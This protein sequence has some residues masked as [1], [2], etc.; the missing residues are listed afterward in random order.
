MPTPVLRAL[1]RL[2]RRVRLAAPA[3]LLLVFAPSLG[4]QGLLTPPTVTISPAQASVNSPGLDITVSFYD[5]DGLD[6]SS[7]RMYLNGVDVTAQFSWPGSGTSGQSSGRVQLVAGDN[8]FTAEIMDVTETYGTA[9]ASYT[10]TAAPPPGP[11]A[12]APLPARADDPAQTAAGMVHAG[13]S[14]RRDMCVTIAAGPGAAYEC[15]DLRLAHALAPIRVLNAARTPVL[16]YNSQHASP[17][18]VLQFNLPMTAGAAPSVVTA[19]LRVGAVGGTRVER[20]RRTWSDGAWGGGGL[21]RFAISYD[22]STDATSLYQYEIEVLGTF[23]GAQTRMAL[24]TGDL[25]VVNRS[26]HEFGAGWSLAG[27]ERLIFLPDGARSLLVSGDGS[28]RVYRWAYNSTSLAENVDRPDSLVGV[29]INGVAHYTRRLPNGSVVWFD[30]TGRHYKTVTR[31]GHTTWF[32]YDGQGRLATI[33]LPRPAASTVE[34]QYYFGYDDQNGGGRLLYACAVVTGYACRNT[35]FAFGWNDRRL[36][37][38]TDVDERVVQFGYE[39][40]SRQVRTRTDRRGNT[41]WFAYDAAGKLRESS[42]AV[43]EMS[44]TIVNTFSAS[45]SAGL[46]A[47]VPVWNAFTLYDGPR[48][49]VPDHTS[50]WVNRWGA[51]TRTRNALGQLTYLTRSDTRFPALVTRVDNPDSTVTSAGYDARGNV[52]VQTDWSTSRVLANG[53]TAFATQRYTR[54]NAAWPDFVTE[55]T[56]PEGQVV[57][58]DYD[59]AGN[60][61]WQQTGRGDSTRVHFTWTDGQLTAVQTEAARRRGEQPERYAYGTRGNLSRVTSPLG[62][63]SE[64]FQDELGRD[65]ATVAPVD[66]T[67]RLRTSVRYD[68][69]GGDTLTITDGDATEGDLYV[70]KVFDAEGNPTMVR[71]WSTYDPRQIGTVTRNYEYDAAGRRISESGERLTAVRTYYDPAGNV[72][73]VTDGN[74]WTETAYDTLSRPVRRVTPARE[75]A[76]EGRYIWAT[77]NGTVMGSDVYPAFPNTAAGSFLIPGDT[78]VFRYHPLSGALIAADNR[79]AQIRRTYYPNGALKTDTLRIRTW[80]EI[81]EGG[82]FNQ[83]VYA[84]EFGY[85]L[86]GRRTWMEHPDAIEPVNGNTGERYSRQTYGYDSETGALAVVRDVLGLEYTFHYNAE[87]ALVETRHP[88]GR[89]EKLTY[90]ADGRRT[91]RLLTS[92]NYN[93]VGA[94]LY[95][96][97]DVDYGFDQR[98]MPSR[99]LDRGQDPGA[100][101]DHYFTYTQLG[102]VY[103]VKGSGYGSG[104]ASGLPATGETYRWDALGNRLQHQQAEDAWATVSEYI[105]NTTRLSSSHPPDGVANSGQPYLFA[106]YD[107]AGN[108]VWFTADNYMTN[109][110]DASMTY[111]FRATRSYYG[112]DGKLRAS[113]GNHCY[114]QSAPGQVGSVCK[115]PAYLTNETSGGFE[116]YRYDALGRRVLAR[117]RRDHNCTNSSACSS[118]I[119]RFVWDGDQILYEIQAEGGNVSAV[120]LESDNTYGNQYGRVLYTHGPGIDAPLDIIRMDHTPPPGYGFDAWGG[121][122]PVLPFGNWRGTFVGG[123]TAQGVKLPCDATYCLVAWPG[124]RYRAFLERDRP[125]HQQNFFGSLTTGQENSN[126]LMYMRNRYY[127]PLTGAFTQTDPI[128]LAGGLNSY[129]YAE[130]NPVSYS[131]PYGLSAQSN[132]C[133]LNPKLCDLAA[134]AIGGAAI[135]AGIQM[136]S[137]YAEGRPLGE[138]VGRAALTGGAAGAAL[139]GVGLAVKGWRGTRGARAAAAAASGGDD[140]F[141]AGSIVTRAVNTP[142][143]IV[144]L[145]ATIGI[146]G[147]HL[148]LG[149]VGVFARFADEV[150]LGTREMLGIL[151]PILNEARDAGF[152]T[153]RITGVRLGGATPR[154]IAD[155]TVTLKK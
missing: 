140:V 77:Y 123:T 108:Q 15:G 83:H 99:A 84:T 19:I 85:D 45:E 11:P 51:P 112:A 133:L 135:G 141:R 28:T 71:R 50:I 46:P 30:P 94:G 151:R 143:G 78:T 57:R 79:D 70:R 122:Y 139:G 89:T 76:A 132:P 18:P 128:G 120:A 75:H 113:D 82:N 115:G 14:V 98:G 43:P 100:H 96:I 125:V 150:E 144:D 47:S 2:S 142:A 34:A 39:G 41:T 119:T 81:A 147:T 155:F 3:L 12:P 59:A 88:G 60:R 101:G 116:W 35:L 8:W 49:D 72:V 153:V 36:T 48:T 13:G 136:L 67:R 64:Y 95:T 93:G 21:W 53:T 134:G 66:G 126:G 107:D 149:N 74:G 87:G 148:T 152:E 111:Q 6:P 23:G 154:R 131:D 17:S 44:H 1:R 118:T 127:N 68:A 69:M 33:T 80:A 138:G 137:N 4:A 63:Y 27:L 130:G 58:M 54:A 61:V 32:H 31:H 102:R 114:T 9:N 65:T 20:A 104:G 110:D 105:A 52:E 124:K 10:Y 97:S 86:S 55:A 37:H 25:A 24:Y 91:R 106:E 62:F 29:W 56:L 38:I 42:L 103:D 90:D 7:Y 145:Q 5:A 92:P 16:L 129:G 109:V 121:P 40:A 117:V 146:E 73:R 26:G 22:A